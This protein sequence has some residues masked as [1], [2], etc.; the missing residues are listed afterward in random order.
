VRDEEL[1]RA[2]RQGTL[3]IDCVEM[4]LVQNASDAPVRFMG[5]G[6]LYQDGDAVICFKMYVNQSEN[7]SETQHLSLIT[8]GRAGTL[9]EEQRY[10]NLSCKS[11]DGQPWERQRIIPSM[12]DYDGDILMTGR[13][14]TIARVEKHEKVDPVHYMTMCIFQDIDLP[15]T[16]YIETKTAAATERM[17]SLKEAKFTSQGKDFCIRAIEEGCG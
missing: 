7:V 16:G 9:V 4:T 8:G 15:Y 12:S 1:I 2:L 13:A 10:Y 11:Y 17:M 6:Y 14:H 5:R 3:H